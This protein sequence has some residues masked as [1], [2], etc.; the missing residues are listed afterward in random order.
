[1]TAPVMPHD[2]E[3][4]RAVIGGVLVD[5]DQLD[6]A[7]EI[8]VPTDFFSL[9]HRFTW[10]AMLEL[11]EDREPIDPLTVRV[12]LEQRG[13]LDEVRAAYLFE[14]TDGV[15]RSMNVVAYAA[16]VRELAH[17]RQMITTAR[18]LEA[19]AFD[20]GVPV[21]ELCDTAQK[22][23][24]ELTARQAAGGFVSI[25]EALQ[26]TWAALEQARATLGQHRGI[27][28]LSTGYDDLDTLS[29]G[30]QPGSTTV[31]GACT[32]VG[33]SAFAGGL[34]KQAAVTLGL[35]SAV[36]SPEMSMHDIAVREIG[37]VARVN[38]RHLLGG[39]SDAADWRRAQEARPILASAPLFIDDTT[40]LTLAELRARARRLHAEHGPLRLLVV[41]YVQLVHDPG[42]RAENRNLELGAISWALRGLAKELHVPL[43]V[44]SQLNRG[45]GSRAGGR[46]QLSD[47]RDSGSLEQDANNVWLLHRVD[48]AVTAEVI[49]AKARHG[50]KGVVTLGW[51]PEQMRFTNLNEALEPG[52]FS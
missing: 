38:V 24:L 27:T 8:V 13:H 30:L 44:L 28:G 22:A 9:H 48:D 52:L 16:R 20:Q 49:V 46:P 47:L 19:R 51:I 34:I 2:P 4:E 39:C 6:A 50:Q 26:H 41:D 15:P 12:R 25:G 3:A 33:K 21:I 42:L 23:V 17:R 31:V 40:T 43:V 32:S 5:P 18:K 45:A 35:P 14:L 11:A 1:M 7:A 29:G 36:F 10:E 37:L